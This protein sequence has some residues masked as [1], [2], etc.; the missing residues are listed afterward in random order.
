M[1]VKDQAKQVIDSLPEN[2]SMD[3]VLHALYV[4]I[5]FARG[6]AEIRAGRGIS[7]IKAARRLK[8]WVR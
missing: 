4:H 2:V 1:S 7:H 5:K 6:E 3:D 8:K